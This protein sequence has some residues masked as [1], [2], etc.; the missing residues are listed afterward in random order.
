MDEEK[1]LIQQMGKKEPFRVPDGY[2]ESFTQNLMENLPEKE[3]SP[4]A[5]PV[6]S[7]WERVKPWLYL[8]A[9]FMGIIAGAKLFVGNPEKNIKHDIQFTQADVEQ[10]S[11]EGWELIIEDAMLDDNTFVQYFANNN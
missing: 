5:T 2:F 9:M 6:P 1:K 8:A 3:V 11:E 10:I 4:S 7:T